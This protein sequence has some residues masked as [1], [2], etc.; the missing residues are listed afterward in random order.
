MA[1][2]SRWK[3][4]LTCRLKAQTSA[5]MPL[6]F[7]IPLKQAQGSDRTTGMLRYGATNI[8]TNCSPRCSSCYQRRPAICCTWASPGPS[9]RLRCWGLICIV[10]CWRRQYQRERL[11]LTWYRA[12]PAAPF[13]KQRCATKKCRVLCRSLTQY[14]VN[15]VAR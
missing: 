5:V 4:R 11:I 7:F 14:Q 10:W 15:C 6:A 1:R 13:A 3:C 2:G 9:W 12:L 8:S